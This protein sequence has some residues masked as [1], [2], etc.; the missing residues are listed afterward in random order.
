MTGAD[1]SPVV[2][3]DATAV[4]AQSGGAGRYVRELIRHLPATGIHPAVL[5]RRADRD[6]VDTLGPGCGPGVELLPVAPT[7]RVAR[8]IWEQTSLLR[9]ARR[10]RPEA[11]IVHSPHYTMPELRRGSR[12]ARIVTVHDATFFTRPQD[13]EPAKRI[14]FRRATAVAARRA[15]AV[16]V[17]TRAVADALAEHVA[18]EVPIEVIHHG[19]DTARFTT[20]PPV[21]GPTDD[22]VLARL[23]IARPFVLHLGAI[24]PRKNVDVLC[25]AVEELTAGADAHEGLSLVIAGRAWRGALDRLPQAR[26][27]PRHV[28]GFVADADAAALLRSA[29]VVAYPTSEEG[30]G[31]PVVEALACG[32]VVVTGATGATAEI[33]AGAAILVRPRDVADLAR[34]I[35]R[36]LRDGRRGLAPPTIPT[37][38]ACAAAHAALYRRI[39]R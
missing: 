29:E 18:I 28:L 14:L 34:G 13:H 38:E 30:F 33:A 6:G 17:P 31:L 35:D 22:E 25:D 26:R 5:C 20:A 2:V 21:G 16:I 37:W 36:A 32:A 12:P 23:G 27:V 1:G 3:I 4:H 8:L 9:V 10:T 11:D 15:D 39:G 24:E 7:P 19:V